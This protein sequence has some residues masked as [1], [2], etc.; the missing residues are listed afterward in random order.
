MEPPATAD[1]N[2]LRIGRKLR[3]MNAIR[4]APAKQLPMNLFML[5]MVG[6]SVGIFPIY[7]AFMTISSGFTQLTQLSSVFQAF[8]N[9]PE[10]SGPLKLSKAIYAICS[11]AMLLLG[12]MKLSWMGLLPVSAVD[13][14]SHEPPILQELSFIAR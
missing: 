2:E 14:I 1:Q 11:L 3:K 10:V 6:N 13:W 12:C 9:D 5:W 7:F 4:F 8:D